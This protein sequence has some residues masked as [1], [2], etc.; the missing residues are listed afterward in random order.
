MKRAIVVFLLL[1]VT[2]PD[3]YGQETSF[4]PFEGLVQSLRDLTTR[5]QGEIA[6]EVTANT[7]EFAL[8][9]LGPGVYA[10]L[11]EEGRIDKQLGSSAGN[12]GSTSLVSKGSVPA[13]LG[14]A[15]EGGALYQSVSD[16]VVTFR[17]NPAGLVRA[18]ASQ[19]YLSAGTPSDEVALAQVISRMSLS[20]SFDFEQGASP[21]TF[22][23]ER[24]QL[25][26]AT[27]RFN[28]INQRD[29]R[30]PSHAASIQRL[31]GDMGPLVATVQALFDTLRSLPG[32][33]D[34]RSDAAMRLM[35]VDFQDDTALIAAVVEIGI[36]FNGTFAS[37]PNFRRLATTMVDSVRSYRAT[38]D[39]VFEGIARG[40]TLTFEYAFSRMAVPEEVLGSFPVGS[41]VPDLS[42]ARLIL[43]SPIGNVGEAT[44][45]G[46]VTFFNSTLPQMEGNLRDAQ[47]GVAVDLRLPEIQSVGKPVLTFAGLA[48]FLRQQPFGVRVALQG[49][50][51][52][53]G[54]VGVFQ[55]K[56]TFPVGRAG[57]RIPVSF[58]VANRSEFNTETEVRGAIGLTFDMD[59]LFSRP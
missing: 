55:M 14:L 42:S 9:A 1:F 45:N 47:V 34:W 30:H 25:R 6:A 31:R 5:S 29:P 13:L 7:Q 36:E 59:K 17:L 27:V 16:S 35:G 32:Y 24:S 54:T 33:D 11:V 38:R 2:V 21:G 10:S 23:G 44:L 22:T 43:S 19:S 50:E 39:S 26:E 15:V 52:A 48:A 49:V 8:F 37:D 28:L 3:S 58:T 18:L 41:S 4:V 53:D 46:S 40:S 56:L 51:T 20:A 12:S 57:V